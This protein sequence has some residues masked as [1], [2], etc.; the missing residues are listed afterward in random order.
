MTIDASVD[1]PTRPRDRAVSDFTELTRRVQ[2][3]GLMRRRPGHYTARITAAVFAMGALVAGIV[4]V[5]DSWW[6]VAI[7]VGAAI[8]LTQVAFLG[9]DA[10]HRQIFTNGRA[11]TWTSLVL[12]NLFVGLSYGW[13]QHKHTRHHAKPNQVGADP[14]IDLE[15]IAFTPDDIARHRSRLSRWFL[16]KQGWFFFPLL[17]LEGLALHVAAIKRV[18]SREPME[19]RGVEISM[20]AVRLLGGLGLVLL[21]MSPTKAVVFLAVQLALFGFYMGASFA[22]NHKGM[23]LIPKDARIDFLRRQVLT[24]RNIGGGRWVD[25]L[26]GGLNHQ[27]EH[28]LFPSMPRPSLR[29]AQPLVKAYCQAHNIPYASVSLPRSYAIIVRHLNSV[30]RPDRDLFACP[31]TAAYRV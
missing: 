24:S 20:L 11:N 31:V 14:D 1:A 10:A 9:H 17:F 3:A 26:M 28:H 7:A 22:P 23:P 6:Q 16:R 12:A 4:L 18:A 8:I 2:A 27:V 30:G 21:V 15:V 25:V 19:R 29:R 5:G 13:W